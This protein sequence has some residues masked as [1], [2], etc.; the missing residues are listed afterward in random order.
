MLQNA[1]QCQVCQLQQITKMIRKLQ[2]EDVHKG[3]EE[4]EI[5]LSQMGAPEVKGKEMA[6][7]IAGDVKVKK[8]TE[9]ETEEETIG[10]MGEV[11]IEVIIKEIIEEEGAVEVAEEVKDYYHD[12]LVFIK[13]LLVHFQCLHLITS[14]LITNYN[15]FNIMV[16]IFFIILY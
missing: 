4:R 13:D 15:H 14:S 5:K 2:G 3:Q 11:L 12:P 10:E 8:E 7:E 1:V 9:E 6:G 16:L